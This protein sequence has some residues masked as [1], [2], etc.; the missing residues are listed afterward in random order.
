[1]TNLNN[2]LRWEVYDSSL[3]D[4][5]VL[6]GENENIEAE[7]ANVIFDKLSRIEMNWIENSEHPGII[8]IRYPGFNE[9]VTYPVSSLRTGLDLLGAISTYYN[10]DISHLFTT[11]GIEKFRHKAKDFPLPTEGVPLYAITIPDT[12]FKELYK[13]SDGKYYLRLGY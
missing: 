11:E 5:A 3:E 2:R 1:M 6:F 13:I 8:T 9:I 10:K 4:T 7:D 12:S